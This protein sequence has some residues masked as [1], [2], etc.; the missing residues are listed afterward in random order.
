MGAGMASAYHARRR[1][2]KGRGGMASP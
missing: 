2:G 1:A